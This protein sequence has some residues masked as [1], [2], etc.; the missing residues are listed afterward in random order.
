MHINATFL[1]QII[2]F[3]I[4]YYVLN[5]FLFKPVIAS[6]RKKQE[7][8][9]AL[10]ASIEK[11]ENDIIAL[12]KEKYESIISFQRKMRKKFP[13]I[14]KTI[15]DK[16]IDVAPEIARPKNPKLQKEVTDFLVKRVPDVC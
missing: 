16:P 1:V 13:Y 9:T 6:I 14:S 10:K 7:T 4:S 11:E 15:Q 3:L 2:N 8:E 5:R 12:K